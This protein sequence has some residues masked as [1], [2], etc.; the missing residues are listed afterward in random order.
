MVQ[1][2]MFRTGHCFRHRGQGICEFLNFV[3]HNQPRTLLVFWSADCLLL[4]VTCDIALVDLLIENVP[5]FTGLLSFRHFYALYS[6]PNIIR[7][8]KSR[9]L[10][11]AG[12]VAR[13]GGERS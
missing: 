6:S 1:F 9:R 13:G 11:W 3:F 8:I 7:V 10:R 4:Q 12:H 5:V 2:A